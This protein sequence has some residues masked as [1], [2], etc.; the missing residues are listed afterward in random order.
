MV[1]GHVF[2]QTFL[3]V[4]NVPKERLDFIQ[5]AQ[6]QLMALQLALA[7]MQA[8]AMTARRARPGKNYDRE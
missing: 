8:L 3:T 7:S 2:M 5:T 6:F 1:C 4:I